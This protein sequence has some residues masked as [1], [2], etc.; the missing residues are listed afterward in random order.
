VENRPISNV[1]AVSEAAGSD[2]QA[3]RR[4][5]PRW[6]FLL[7]VVGVELTILSTPFD[8]YARLER[9]PFPHG[10][11]SRFCTSSVQL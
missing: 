5:V 10:F 9:E 11:A 8:T 7:L 1:L 3:I 2:G 6:I 4:A